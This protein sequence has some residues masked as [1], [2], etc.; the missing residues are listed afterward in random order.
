[1]IITIKL[2][3]NKS[4][5]SKIKS[6]ESV[7]RQAVTGIKEIEEV[8]RDASWGTRGHA[9]GKEQLNGYWHDQKAARLY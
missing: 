8:A 2:I 3:N 4:K 9:E 5:F 7:I 1:M 6:N